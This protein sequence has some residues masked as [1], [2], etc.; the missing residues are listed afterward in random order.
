MA[1]VARLRGSVSTLASICVTLAL[2]T[3]VGTGTV[4]FLEQQGTAGIRTAIAQRAGADLALRASL[5]L[6]ANA[7]RQ[8]EQVRAA[9]DTTFAGTGIGV[10]VT[11]TLESHVTIRPLLE[12]EPADDID[13]APTVDLPGFAMSIPDFEQRVEFVDGV[14]PAAPNEVAVQATAADALALAVGDEV[15]VDGFGFVVVGTWQPRDFLDPQWYG[16]PIVI[17]GVG[18]EFGPF[19]IEES[20]WGRLDRSPAATWTV[21][22][23]VSQI[24]SRNIVEVG[25]RWGS[26]EDDW[27][28]QVTDLK[29][30][31][32]QNRLVQTLKEL[33]S[34]LDGLRAVEPVVFTL[35]GAAALVGVAELA[36]L[37]AVI[38]RRDNLLYWARGRSARGVGLGAALDVAV[39]GLVGAALGAG[40]ATAAVLLAGVTFSPWSGVGVWITALVVTAAGTLLA[41]IH[42]TRTSVPALDRVARRVGARIAVPGVVVLVCVAAAVSVWQLRLYGSPLTPTADGVEGVDPIAVLAPAAALAA[43]TLVL[44]ML[45]PVIAKANERRVRGG[46]AIAQLA[47]RGVSRRL[48]MA[49]APLVLV[50]LAAGTSTIAATY[51]A[52]WN[53]A[54]TETVA[55]RVGSDFQASSRVEGLP[56]ASQD[57]VAKAPGV[58]LAAPLEVQPLILGG[59]SGTILGVTPDAVAELAVSVP[60]IFDPAS[61][62]QAIRSETPGVLLPEGATGFTV[63]ITTKGIQQPP[64]LSAYLSDAAGFLRSVALAADPGIPGGYST[65]ELPTAQL[66]MWKIVALDFEFAWQSFEEQMGE[67]TLGSVSSRSGGDEQELALDQFWLADGYSIIALPPS[68]NGYGNGFSLTEFN[69]HVRMTPSISG[70]PVDGGK[71]PVLISQQLADRFGVEVGQFLSF[72]L[73]DGVEMQNYPVAGIVPVIPGARTET[74]VMLDLGVIQHFQLRSTE[75]PA[76]PRN[77]WITTDEPDTLTAALRPVLPANARIDSSGDPSSREVLGSAA[78]SLWGAAITVSLLALL[79]VIAA[80]RARLRAGRNDVGVLRAIGLGSREQASLLSRELLFTQLVALLGGIA[81]GF[82]V[83]ALTIP[84]FARAAITEPYFAIRTALGV[85][86]IGLA[87]LLLSLCL[88]LALVVAVIRGRVGRLAATAK[89][90][91]EGE[92]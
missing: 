73:Q 81:I 35:M 58:T 43:L 80:S 74:A 4:V 82:L 83:S 33:Q 18:A 39:A 47:A 40:V 15:L 22:P 23:D 32:F 79:G 54:F 84:F 53:G 26:I 10:T 20:A 88:G 46:G 91:E 78:I 9:I 65:D 7:A 67:V 92:E 31:A 34:R 44:L 38:R 60:G 13:I 41:A 42:A 1:F 72:D 50:T 48:A 5:A 56:L 2:V 57:A 19:V 76:A 49:A 64:T 59:E 6:D 61:A 77:L 37:L 3:A 8:D 24:D 30:L 28:G 21:L 11:R 87:A 85:D 29:T 52:T 45:L 71:P 55:L 27:R 14:A 68:T 66:G 62:A 75:V 25:Q 36:R 17:E 51:S 70:N 63:V 69:E 16:N 90:D 12:V 86:V 89:P